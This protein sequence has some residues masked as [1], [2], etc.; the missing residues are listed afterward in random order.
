MLVFASLPEVTNVFL[1][2][3][4]RKRAALMHCLG[5]L[6]LTWSLT[7]TPSCQRAAGTRVR[8]LRA[9]VI[10]QLSRQQEWQAAPENSGY[11]E[12]PESAITG[13]REL[14][15]VLES[16]SQIATAVP[17][18]AA[19]EA[20]C[21][22]E[23]WLDGGFEAHKFIHKSISRQ[24]YVEV[25]GCLHTVLTRCREAY[26]DLWAVLKFVPKKNG[27]S[28]V[29]ALLARGGAD[30]VSVAKV[31]GL[32]PR[33]M[34]RQLD[35]LQRA[36]EQSWAL[37]SC[38][39]TQPQSVREDLLWAA[40][41]V[42]EK[43]KTDQRSRALELLCLGIFGR[44]AALFPLIVSNAR[45][46]SPRPALCSEAYEEEPCVLSYGGDGAAAKVPAHHD[47]QPSREQHTC[48]VRSLHALCRLPARCL[49][50]V[51]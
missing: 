13:R 16:F 7:F 42:T 25:V 38:Y 51:H 35:D 28:P 41:T 9:S 44:G 43:I 15:T 33:A 27:L 32:T 19:S 36:F 6:A 48:F 17:V 39:L 49:C 2:A 12:W 47:S 40:R 8:L 26:P 18:D 21:Q 22:W 5:L 46:A 24:S 50:A 45:V 3:D 11:P 14:S 4:E 10:L 31:D 30:A 34:R 23:A 1:A 20:D 29:L 37:L